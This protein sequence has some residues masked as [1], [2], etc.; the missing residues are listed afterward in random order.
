VLQSCAA[1]LA[2]GSKAYS[3]GTPCYDANL[4]AGSDYGI[5]FYDAGFNLLALEEQRVNI[6][7]ATTMVPTSYYPTITGVSPAS[8]TSIPA[9]ST[10][11]TV[12]VTSTAPAGSI[13][14]AVSLNYSVTNVGVIYANTMDVTPSTTPITT[15]FSVSGLSVAPTNG[16][17]GTDDYIGGIHVSTGLQF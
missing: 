12:T 15:A 4:V 2:S 6:S 7:P 16:F 3:S 9:G 13:G 10:T 5:A 8:A 14:G 17:A 1:I 11:T